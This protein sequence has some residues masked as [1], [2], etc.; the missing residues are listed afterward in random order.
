[1]CIAAEL[2]LTALCGIAFGFLI[3]YLAAADRRY[4]R[5]VKP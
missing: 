2:I 1:M 3:D 4:N 5:R